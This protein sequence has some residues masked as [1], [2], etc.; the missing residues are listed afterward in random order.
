MNWAPTSSSWTCNTAC[1]PPS[2]SIFSEYVDYINSIVTG[3]H[4]IFHFPRYGIMRHWVESGQVDFNT[5]TP[6]AKQRSFTFVHNCLG[7]LLA[8]SIITMTLDP[9]LVK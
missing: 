1:K 9:E 4:G 2:S 3:N 5:E 8:D 6:E 7:K